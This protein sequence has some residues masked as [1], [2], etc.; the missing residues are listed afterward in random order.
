MLFKFLGKVG[1]LTRSLFNPPRRIRK[2]LSN[3]RTIFWRSLRGILTSSIAL[4]WN[5]SNTS[6]LSPMRVSTLFRFLIALALASVASGTTGAL[7]LRQTVDSPH[8]WLNLGRAPSSHIIPLRIALRQPRF[9]ELEHHLS[10]SSDPFHPNYGKHLSKEEVEALVAPHPSSVDAVHEWLESHGVQKEACH[11]SPAGDCVTVNLPVMQVEKMLGTEFRV[12]KHAEDGD[13]LVRTT[14][15]SLPHHLDEHIEL[16]QPTTVFN[17]A[18]PQRTTYHFV[19]PDPAAPSQVSS[20]KITVPGSGVTVDASCNTTITVSCLKQLYNAVNYVPQ[21]ADN[22]SIALTGYKEQFA[23]FADLK[24]FYVDQV[25]AAVNTSFD[26]VLVNGGLNNQALDMAG[27]E[28][29]LDVQFALGISFPTPGIFYSTGG[30][31]PFIED[32]HMSTTTNEPYGDWLDF[33]LAQDTIPSVISTSY[34]DDEQSVPIDY[35]NR[36]CRGFAQLAVRGIS[37]LFSSGDSG[38]GD[39]NPDPATQTCF[40]NDGKNQT[41]FIP[42][43]PASCPY[44]TAVGGTIQIPEVASNVSGGGFSNYFERPSWQDAAVTKYL[45]SLP[46]GTYAGLFNSSGRAFPDISAQANSFRI[47]YRGRPAH[48]HGT[49]ASAPT[50]AGIV[51]LLNDARIAA[52]RNPLGFLNPLIYSMNGTGFNDI[53]TGNAPGCG[54][55]GFNATEGWDPLTGCGTPNFEVLKEI[56]QTS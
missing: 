24:Q 49:S 5:L 17:R 39:G 19:D 54:T 22:N 25:P 29:N 50:I 30:R 44:V 21:S 23:N 14:Q 11:Q 35:A 6:W 2:T 13:A 37:M 45:E 15:Y 20:E 28:A 9:S 40:T 12:W 1:R 26:V 33:I 36:L 46:K 51:A 32:A 3:P 7:K 8:N 52:G 55:P 31:A 42:V 16:I 53:T 56:A 34:G 41:R 18:K 4:C 38:V 10:E 48:I 47:I 27:A 43:F